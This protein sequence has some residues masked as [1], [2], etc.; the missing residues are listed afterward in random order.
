MCRLSNTQIWA[1][2]LDI[3]TR[4]IRGGPPETKRALVRAYVQGGVAVFE[5]DV[6]QDIWGDPRWER[7]QGLP[8]QQGGITTASLVMA[9]IGKTE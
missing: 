9:L 2:K 8:D 7:I 5:Q 6:S 1:G 4:M 3:I